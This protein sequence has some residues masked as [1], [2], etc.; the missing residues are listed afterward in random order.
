[1]RVDW[2]GLSSDHDDLRRQLAGYAEAG[3][4]HVI[5]SVRQ[6]T[7]DDWLRSVEALRD[8]AASVA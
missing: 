3:I 7:I 6:N 8:L 5:T 2:D 1:M 4:S